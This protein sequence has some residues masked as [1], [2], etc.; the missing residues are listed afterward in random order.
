MY[1]DLYIPQRLIEHL[2]FDSQYYSCWGNSDKNMDKFVQSWS[3]HS[4]RGND[5]E[6]R[7]LPTAGDDDED[8]KNKAPG[9]EDLTESVTLEIN[10]QGSEEASLNDAWR[11]LISGRGKS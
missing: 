3:L 1:E 7:K 8:K 11:A 5:S 4:S 6:Q 9:Q 2:L 10:P